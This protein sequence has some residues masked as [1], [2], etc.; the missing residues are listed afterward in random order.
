MPGPSWDA[1]PGTARERE[2]THDQP[3]RA[4]LSMARYQEVR[5][6]SFGR[7]A[8]IRLGLELVDFRPDI[9]PEEGARALAPYVGDGSSS[10]SRDTVH[11]PNRQEDVFVLDLG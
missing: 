7:V 11:V 6:H 4:G 3:L 9:R 5:L 1:G 10:A 8:L 2:T